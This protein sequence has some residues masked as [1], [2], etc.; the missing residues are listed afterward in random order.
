MRERMRGRQQRAAHRFHPQ[1]LGIDPVHFRRRT[2]THHQVGIAAAQH[3]PMVGD[4]RLGDRQL[5]LRI[6]RRDLLRGARQ[7]RQPECGPRRGD[8]AASDV[9]HAGQARAPHAVRQHVEHDTQGA[10]VGVARRGERHAA[11]APVEQTEAELRFQ[12]L[13]LPRERRLCDVQT[14]RRLTE[15][16]L[17][18]DG[19]E[20]LELS[21]IHAP[22]V[23]DAEELSEGYPRGIVH[24][25]RGSIRRRVHAI[26]ME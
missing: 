22:G 20:V 10:Q 25:G 8:H 15:S 19:G 11:P 3:F 9:P 16:A 6:A 26:R 5:D 2:D 24:R 23:T 7:V 21:E 12:C 18:C 4:V 1:R 13:D 14:C 17:G